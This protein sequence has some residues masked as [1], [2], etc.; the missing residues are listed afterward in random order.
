MADVFGT[1]LGQDSGV[2]GDSSTPG[3]GPGLGP[4]LDC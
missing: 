2:G 4:R 1:F 3:P